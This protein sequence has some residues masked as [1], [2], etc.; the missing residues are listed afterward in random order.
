VHPAGGLSACKQRVCTCAHSHWPRCCFVCLCVCLQ[1][2][3]CHTAAG[4]PKGLVVGQLSDVCVCAAA[5]G[6]RLRRGVWSFPW[7]WQL[8]Q[9]RVLA[10]VPQH[11]PTH[12]NDLTLTLHARRQ[13]RYVCAQG[14]EAHCVVA[15]TAAAAAAAAAAV[16]GSTVRGGP[17]WM[18]LSRSS[19][20]TAA[21]WQQLRQRRT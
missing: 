18:L 11:S 4:A 12:C 10:A 1:L 17:A 13:I 15:C 3:D 8:W 14:T 6:V 19:S 2:G 20:T 7:G 5:C 16:A 9:V 21:P